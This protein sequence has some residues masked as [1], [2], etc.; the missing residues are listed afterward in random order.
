MLLPERG[1]RMAAVA[2]GLVARGDQ[3]ERRPLHAL[4]LALGDSQLGRVD[5]IVGRIYERH[6]RHDAFE[7]RRRV[8]VAG[9]LDLVDKV[10]AADDEVD[11]LL[12]LLLKKNNIQL[13]E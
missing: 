5:E 6:R 10:V 2:T 3:H 1:P 7:F 11:S 8:V 9:R 4:H 13:P 12:E